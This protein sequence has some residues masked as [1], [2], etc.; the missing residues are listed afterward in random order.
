[1]VTTVIPSRPAL[2]GAFYDHRVKFGSS[3]LNGKAMSAEEF[4]QALQD[5]RSLP[6]MM[7]MASIAAVCALVAA[8]ALLAEMRYYEKF[9]KEQASAEEQEPAKQTSQESQPLIDDKWQFYLEEMT[10]LLQLQAQQERH[11]ENLLDDLVKNAVSDK[12]A[13]VFAI[14]PLKAKILLWLD[15]PANRTDETKRDRVLLLFAKLNTIADFQVNLQLQRQNLP[16]NLQAVEE[17]LARNIELI[18]EERAVLAELVSAGVLNADAV[19]KYQ[20]E[21]AKQL[22]EQEKI[23]LQLF[24]TAIEYHNNNR[25]IDRLRPYTASSASYNDHAIASRLP[26]VSHTLQV[27]QA[28]IR[29]PIVL[30]GTALTTD[31]A[32]K[33]RIW[34]KND[35][36]TDP[37]ST[38]L[39]QRRAE[40][41]ALIKCPITGQPIEDPV[42]AADGQIYEREAIERRLKFSNL[43]PVTGMPFPNNDLVADDRIRAKVAE[44]RQLIVDLDARIEKVAAVEQAK[45]AAI[46]TPSAPAASVEHV[47]SAAPMPAEPSAP[48]EEKERRKTSPPGGLTL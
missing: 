23:Y 18:M 31:L 5:P 34:A 46:P 20:A 40:L 14:E 4:A 12:L 35:D 37:T 29:R 7:Q 30:V 11:I 47:K 36:L 9:A 38:D 24:Q 45:A 27:W 48:E 33:V 15:D 6:Y 32:E 1:M 17:Y 42:R 25:S 13:R 3:P 22:K 28:T 43:S 41:V 19:K 10:R 21:R 16:H 44:V 8:Q 2:D 26:A 39:R